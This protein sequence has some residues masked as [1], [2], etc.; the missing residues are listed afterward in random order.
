QRAML[1]IVMSTERDTILAAFGSLGLPDPL[2]ARIVR[3]PNTLHLEDV[4]V[5]EPL[6]RELEGRPHIAALESPEPM[7]FDDGGPR[8]RPAS[9][10]W[11]APPRTP[12]IGR[13]PGSKRSERCTSW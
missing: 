5:S 1:P 10:G 13:S 3:A 6:V 2:R 8:G 12:R 7:R 4:W 11:P 9:R